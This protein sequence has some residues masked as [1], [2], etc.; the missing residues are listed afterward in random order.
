MA[1]SIK[2]R[3][4]SAKAVSAA[5][6]ETVHAPITSRPG[7]KLGV[8]LE[9][10]SAK[11]GATAAEL[12]AATGWQTHSVLGALSKLKAR[13]F[14]IRLDAEAGRKAYRLDMAKG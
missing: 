2:A 12:V 5:A 4:K 8:I 9:H 13:G 14:A 3:S 6:P 10:L 7:G 1:K 11:T